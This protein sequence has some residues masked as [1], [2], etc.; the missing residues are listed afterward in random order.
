M[1][2]SVSSV[3]A[4]VL[5]RYMCCWGYRLCTDCLLFFTGVICY[6]EDI[7]LLFEK[8]LLFHKCVLHGGKHC[9]FACFIRKRVIF[10]GVIC[11][12]EDIS[13]LFEKELLF[14]KCVLHVGNTSILLDLK[15]KVLFLQELSAMKKTFL[16][17]QSI[18]HTFR[19][20]SSPSRLW[21]KERPGLK[22][23]SIH[24]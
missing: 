21:W 8:E 17:W 3:C 12:E 18:L 23:S 16:C 1:K 24:W 4:S 19:S 2:C 6:E 9:Y 15:R 14:H 10:A 22:V 13:L 5:S 7:S 11:Y 20:W